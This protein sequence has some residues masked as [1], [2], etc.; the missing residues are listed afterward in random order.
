MV[1][2][3]KNTT[4]KETA[5]Y[6]NMKKATKETLKLIAVLGLILFLLPSAMMRMVFLYEDTYP[7]SFRDAR[8][9]KAI[10][11][12][13][14]R[15]EVNLSAATP[16]EW[17]TVYYINDIPMEDDINSIQAR[18]HVDLNALRRVRIGKFDLP[19]GHCFI[20][21]KD[22]KFVAD[23]LMPASFAWNIPTKPV[24]DDWQYFG[25][26]ALPIAEAR[27]VPDEHGQF[28]LIGDAA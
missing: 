18:L 17:D 14:E 19:M 5:V 25:Y 10:H 16:F 6:S 26:A 27:F 8:I 24:D 1:S 9:T 7:F 22:G 3:T 11:L 23:L 15:G 2:P 4:S 20:F 13:A 28:H 12:Q 21:I